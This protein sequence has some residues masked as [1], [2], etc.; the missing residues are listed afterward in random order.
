M[1]QYTLECCV[2]SVESAAAAARGG[3]DRLELC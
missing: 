2:D 1:R 3:A